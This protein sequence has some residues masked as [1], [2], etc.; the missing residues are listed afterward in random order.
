VKSLNIISLIQAHES[1]SETVFKLFLSYYNIEIKD[2]E[3]NVLKKFI[4]M[5]DIKK[6]FY[7]DFFVGYKIP[8]I[9]KEFD[10]LKFGEE[11]IINIELKDNSS[12]EKIKRQLKQNR[13]YL[14]FLGKQV[15]HFTFIGDTKCLYYLD[16]DDIKEVE[17][18]EL[19]ELLKNQ[20]IVKIEDINKLF[21]PTNY[22]VSPFIRLIN[23][24]RIIIF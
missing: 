14:S 22:L 16:N 15:H 1:L 10:L 12:E 5:L 13:Y 9:S 7:N 17:P 3:I 19:S 6:R 18:K 8:Q 11:Y 24:C 20:K 4:D 21:D 2:H 23:F